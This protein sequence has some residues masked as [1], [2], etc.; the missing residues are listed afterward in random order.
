MDARSKRTKERVM[1]NSF[2]YFSLPRSVISFAWIASLALPALF[3]GAAA[4]FASQN[5]ATQAQNAPAP[6]P[7]IIVFWEDGF[8][9]SDTAQ[10]ARASLSAIL[11]DAGFT[12]A[13][14]L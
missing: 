12:S 1:R 2:R 10:P 7:A 6:R 4:T 3:F 14:Q 9:A 13:E 8:P 11:P 5:N